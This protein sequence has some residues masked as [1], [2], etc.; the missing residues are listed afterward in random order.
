MTLQFEMVENSLQ[1]NE[2]V[3]ILWFT[4]SM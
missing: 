2:L 1:A 4:I 3:R